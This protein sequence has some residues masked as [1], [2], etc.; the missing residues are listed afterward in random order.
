MEWHAEHTNIILIAVKCTGIK[1]MQY[2][3]VKTERKNGLG[4]TQKT[5]RYAAIT[6]STLNYFYCLIQ[7]NILT[8]LKQSSSPASEYHHDVLEIVM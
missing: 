2:N 1:F 3:T 7:F 6:T 8:K 5:M 4:Y